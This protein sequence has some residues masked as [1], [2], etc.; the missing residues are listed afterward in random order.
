[1]TA[2]RDVTIWCDWGYD[3]TTGHRPC[4]RWESGDTAAEARRELR[5][6]GW[7]YLPNPAR[8]YCPEHAGSADDRTPNRHEQQET[9]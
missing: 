6:Y 3:P 9:A 2:T 8:D 4:T 7:R 5:R 1:M